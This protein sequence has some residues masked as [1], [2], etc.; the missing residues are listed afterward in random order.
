MTDTAKSP[1]KRPV[2]RTG[3]TVVDRDTARRIVFGAT[4]ARHIAIT[5]T[6][7][8]LVRATAARIWDEFET[9][10]ALGEWPVT[11]DDDDDDDDLPVGV[12]QN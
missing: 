6:P 12:G 11:P 1:A 9:Y 8:D 3:A 4:V 5:E 2:Q 10:F 7:E